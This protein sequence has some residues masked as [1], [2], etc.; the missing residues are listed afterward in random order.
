MA[1]ERDPH[2]IVPDE[3]WDEFGTIEAAHKAPS[4]T[5]KAEQ[6]RC[7]SCDSIN[8]RHKPG[9]PV[10]SDPPHRE[11]ADYRCARCEAHFNEPKPPE[12]EIEA[13]GAE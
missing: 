13:G 3:F 8:I 4:T 10:G 6:K 5:D 11:D 2:G 9:A 12:A 1:S 7:P